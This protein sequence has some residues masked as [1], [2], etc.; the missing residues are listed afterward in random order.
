[1]ERVADGQPLKQGRGLWRSLSLQKLEVCGQSP[2]ACT[3]DAPRETWVASSLSPRW[4]HCFKFL[5]RSCSRAWTG[6]GSHRQDQEAVVSPT[7]PDRHRTRRSTRSPS[8]GSQRGFTIS[9]FNSATA[10]T[11]GAAGV[12]PEVSGSSLA[13]LSFSCPVVHLTYWTEN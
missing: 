3:L 5:L 9:R 12:R 13:S 7:G 4:R 6:Q 10:R 1:M 8:A 11:I 2:C